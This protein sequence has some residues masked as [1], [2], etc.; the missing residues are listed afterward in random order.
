MSM[1]APW[2]PVLAVGMQCLPG[3]VGCPFAGHH[4]LLLISHH[5]FL[6]AWT[7]IHWGAPGDKFCGKMREN[8]P[9]SRVPL[10]CVCMYSVCLCVCVICDACTR[11]FYAYFH[12]AALAFF[13]LLITFF[14]SWTQVEVCVPFL[15]L[16]FARNG[17]SFPQWTLS[18]EMIQFPVYIVSVPHTHQTTS[19][20]TNPR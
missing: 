3:H 8:Q 1:S 16:L 10:C 15:L 2:S 17:S 18:Q 6:W 19:T 9:L 5:I 4:C 20:N 11:K 7:L 12:T 13:L 14:V